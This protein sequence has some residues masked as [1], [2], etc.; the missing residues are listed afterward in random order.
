MLPHNTCIPAEVDA[1][2]GLQIGPK[3]ANPNPAKWPKRIVLHGRYC[4]LEPLDPG[5]HSDH[6]FAASAVSDA[7]ARFLYLPVAAP[8]TRNEFDAW[9]DN[10]SK[11]NDAL[12]F[13]VIDTTT[14][15]AE[16]RQSLMRIDPPNQCI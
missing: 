4:R 13:A 8:A 14:N 6:L 12:Y 1:T 9:I 3:L 16:G 7:A 10:R 5:K 11:F 15:R 2:T